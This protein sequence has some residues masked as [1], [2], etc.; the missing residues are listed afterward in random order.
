MAAAL[1]NVA[2]AGIGG[3]GDMYLE[4]FLPREQTLGAKLVG[5]VDPFPQRCKH[6]ADLRTRCIP[7]H[8]S[9]QSL[10]ASSKID[11]LMI[12]TPIHLHAPQTC[13]ALQRN[14][15]VLCEKPLAGTLN[16]AVRMWHA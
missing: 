11:L 6:L 15:N 8:S 3:Y 5:V 9:V 13:F 16:D 4:A 10:F 12:A 7:I 2:L 14:T 1:V